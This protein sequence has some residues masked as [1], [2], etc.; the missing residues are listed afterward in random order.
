MDLIPHLEAVF[1]LDAHSPRTL[2]AR[3]LGK[4]G[5]TDIYRSMPFHVVPDRGV[6]ASILVAPHVVF[7]FRMLSEVDDTQLAVR[8]LF[9]LENLTWAPYKDS[10]DGLVVPL[11]RHFKGAI[12][13]DNEQQ[14]AS[15]DAAVGFRLPHPLSPMR[16]QFHGGFSLPVDGGDVNWELDLPFGAFQSGLRIVPFTG[17]KVELPGGV[18]GKDITMDDGTK[19]YDISPIA[20]ERGKSMVMTIHGLPSAAAWKLWVPRVFGVV[21]VT[22]MLGGLAFALVGR[23]RGAAAVV[24]D[25]ARDTKRAKLMDELVE[26]DRAGAT[27]GKDRKRRD[28]VIA[29]LEKLW[30]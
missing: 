6:T 8:G 20:I 21:V 3:T 9:D 22:L 15:V 1:Q 5:E 13:G 24:A 28:A 10:P 7:S 18:Q 17:M 11:P 29:E 27:S 2:Y 25:P 14:I 4:G 23:R 12:V 19:L 16:T 26:I 30:D